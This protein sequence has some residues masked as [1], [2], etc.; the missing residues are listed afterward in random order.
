MEGATVAAHTGFIMEH[1]SSTDQF[2]LPSVLRAVRCAVVELDVYGHI[3]G[4]NPE[5][6]RLHACREPDVV[7]VAYL[8]L[9]VPREYRRAVTE[10]VGRV[11]RGTEAVG[12]EYPIV[13]VD[14]VRRCVLWNLTAIRAEGRPPLLVA[15]GQ[16]QT[17]RREAEQRIVRL[18][19]DLR[20][21]LHMTELGVIAADLIQSVGEPLGKAVLRAAHLTHRARRRGHEPMSSIV[22]ELQQIEDQ[23]GNAASLIRRF[24]ASAWIAR[25]RRDRIDL[26]EEIERTATQ[27]RPIGALRNIEFR[28]AAEEGLGTVPGDRLQLRRAIDNLVQNAFEAIGGGPGTIEILAHKT[29]GAGV[30][31]LVADSADGHLPVPDP[32][33]LFVSSKPLSSGTGLNVVRGIV[34]A[35]GGTVG[36]ERNEPCGMVFY[37]DVPTVATNNEK[38]RP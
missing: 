33:A 3:L 19:H 38:E 11:L 12:V 31:V 14:G 25:Q 24:K 22:S 27:W 16:D 34:E 2:R 6:E 30:R 18:E 28:S 37:F 5:A 15:V 8:E 36:Y 32:F 29:R 4:F 23:L 7:G 35:H 10:E 26:A 21:R 13:G 9:F 1:T 17:A 20:G